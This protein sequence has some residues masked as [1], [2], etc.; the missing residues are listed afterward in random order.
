M[1]IHHALLPLIL[2]TSCK[3][4]SPSPALHVE[5]AGRPVKRLR[6][7]EIARQVN[8]S[9][10]TIEDPHERRPITYEAF[11][12]AP[13]LDTLASSPVGKTDLLFRCADGYEARIPEATWRQHGKHAY[14]AFRIPG[15]RSFRVTDVRNGGKQV[16][17]APYYLIWDNRSEPAL[18]QLPGHHWPYQVT[19]ITTGTPSKRRAAIRPPSNAPASALR[20]FE[21]FRRHCIACHAINGEGGSLGPELNYPVSVIQYFDRD[22]LARWIRDPK[23]IRFGST[24]PSLAALGVSE[25]ESSRAI[26]DLVAY[27]EAM[28][29]H[30]VTPR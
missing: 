28:S 18:H 3:R 27:L 15:R 7:G 13:L 2:L 14:L 22:W 17:L 26:T 19:T 29:R 10:V 11:Q 6:V 5:L 1:R 23:Q 16:S 8:A 20:G 30:K 24:M 21:L 4:H 12:L 9:R 25:D